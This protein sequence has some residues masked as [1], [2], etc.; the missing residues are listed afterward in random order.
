MEWAVVVFS[1]IGVVL[2]I[3]KIRWCF[4]I[5]GVTNFS[6]MIIDFYHGVYSQAFLFMIYFI[7]ALYGLYQWSRES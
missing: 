7:L 5:W 1:I 3:Y 2:N 6:W 4:V